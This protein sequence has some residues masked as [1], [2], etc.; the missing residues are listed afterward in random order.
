MTDYYTSDGS[1]VSV[2]ELRDLDPETQRNVMEVWFRTHYED[3]AER[4]PYDSSEGGYIWI[5]G[6]PFHADEELGAEF[7]EIIDQ[8]V[9]DSLAGDLNYECWSWAPTEQPGDYDFIDI[10]DIADYYDNFI[11]ALKNVRKLADT[12]VEDGVAPLLYRLLYI[13]VVTAMET[14]LSDAF[15]N[16]VLNDSALVRKFVETTRH[17]EETKLSLSDVFAEIDRIEETVKVHLG[18]IVWHNLRR[19]RRM[20]LDV[21]SIE[22][23]GTESIFRSINMRHDLVHRNGKTKEGK[24]IP[25]KRGHVLALAQEVE[26]LVQGIDIAL[27]ARK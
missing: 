3:P 15:V 13:N 24:A 25:V 22:V 1:P 12:P 7:G 6:G 2:Q 10:E 26:Q 5:Y 9:I 11:D 27:D 21:L 8:G 23:P 20:Y 14:Y 18:Q 4:T 19:V 16:T 17:F